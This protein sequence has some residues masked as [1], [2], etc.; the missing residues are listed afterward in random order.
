MRGALDRS[1]EIGSYGTMPV[2]EPR[3][4]EAPVSLS[5]RLRNA[6]RGLGIL[7]DPGTWID[8][9]GYV[10]VCAYPARPSHAGA[11]A[12]SRRS[13]ASQSPPAPPCAGPSRWLR[14]GGKPRAR[15]GLHGADADPTRDGGRRHPRGSKGRRAGC[16]PLW[17]RSGTLRHRGGVLP[18]GAWPGL[19][20]RRGRVRALRPGA[21]ETQ[22]Q[23]A[24]VAAYAEQ[25]TT[26]MRGAV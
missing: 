4:E 22:A 12:T 18:R 13:A 16:R 26:S 23:L 19:A 14:P 5:V 20:G 24:T 21:I 10:L 17:R 11:A 6:L 7:R 15:A 1:K 25:H 2:A 8:P 3:P 9:S